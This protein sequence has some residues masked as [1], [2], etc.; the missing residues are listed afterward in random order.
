MGFFDLPAPVFDILDRLMAFLPELI[1]LI[2][3]GLLAGYGSMALFKRFSNQEKIQG[4]KAQVKTNQ[5][6]MAD[7]EGEMNELMPLVGRTLKLAFQQ[8]GAALGPALLVSIPVIFMLAWLSNSYSLVQPEAG[9]SYL[10]E[11]HTTLDSGF[12]QADYNWENTDRVRWGADDQAWGFAW[13]AEGNDLI[14]NHGTDNI[15]TVSAN[16]ISPVVHKKQWW[17]WIIGNPMGYLPADS[18]IDQVMFNFREN[19]VLEVGPGWMHGWMFPFF[20]SFLVFSLAFKFI[21]KIA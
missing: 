10:A 11:V 16:D 14:F 12:N 21:L 20:L 7:F 9:D 6:K 18:N 5:K 13:P 4:L 17:N 1:K 19:K 3:W 8:L 15:L 2:I